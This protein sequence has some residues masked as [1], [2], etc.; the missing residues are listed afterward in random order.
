MPADLIGVALAL[1][2]AVVWGGGDFSGGL[3]TR[4][5]NVNGVVAVAAVAGIVVLGILSL[6]IGE[7]WPRGA[8]LGWA[9][10]AGVAGT[11]GLVA[12]Y[13]GLAAH[14]AAVVAPVS[15]VVGALVPIVYA[16]LAL[17]LPDVTQQ[18]GFAVALPGIWLVTRGTGGARGTA[19]GGMLDGV[20]AGLG[21]GLFFVIIAHVERGTV[22]A[23]LVVARSV[24]LA[25]AL[26]AIAARPSPLPPARRNPIAWLAGALD[27]GG[28]AFYLFALQYTRVD[29]AAVLS[30]LY[31]VTTV[32]LSSWLLGQVVG[33]AQWIGV[34]C[35]LAAVTLIAS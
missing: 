20:L 5:C 15:A 18:V 7:P 9:F 8:D 1:A 23:P 27:T 3:A 21:F 32:L 28:N 25:V 14:R 10:A 2:S 30:S 31:P 13:R 4:R 35:C 6:V 34:A 33:R 22:F 24:T 19:H 17:N 16:V 11:F 26:I 12:L 29:I